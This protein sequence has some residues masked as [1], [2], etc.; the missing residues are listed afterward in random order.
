MIYLIIGLFIVSFSLLLYM[1]EKMYT[2]G[3]KLP[4]KGIKE[5]GVPIVTFTHKGKPL[6]FIVDTGSSNNIISTN[7]YKQLE[8]VDISS[9]VSSVYGV[10]GNNISIGGTVLTYLQCDKKVYLASFEVMN[11]P[12]LDKFS[13]EE[14]I[15]IAG[16]IGSNFLSKYNWVIDFSHNNLYT[17]FKNVKNI[18]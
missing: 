16:F 5:T 8:K 7:V 11:I 12:A 4:L 1:F 6:N 2:K 3:R 14:N 10:D 17:Y 9:E 18:K 15:N 13:S